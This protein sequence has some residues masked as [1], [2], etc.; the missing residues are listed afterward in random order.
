MSG[1]IC[2]L[3]S[4]NLNPSNDNCWNYTLAATREDGFVECVGEMCELWSSAVMRIEVN[5]PAGFE[6]GCAFRIMAE[7]GPT[8]FY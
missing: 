7:K 6:Y 8:V 1:K 4:R 5:K 3:M 2:P